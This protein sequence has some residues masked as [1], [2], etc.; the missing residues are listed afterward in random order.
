MLRRLILGE[1]V[2][3][4]L[5]AGATADFLVRA[6]GTQ[7]PAKQAPEARFAYGGNAA[8]IPAQF[9]GKL[10]FLPVRVSDAQ[11]SLFELDSTAAN[12][13]IAP[14]RASELKLK[15]LTGLLLTLPDVQ[16]FLPELRTAAIENFGTQVGHEYQGTL[17]SDFLSLVVV[18]IDY[19]RQT[20]RIYDPASFKHTG[21]IAPLPLNFSGGLP[22]VHA[23]F[24]VGGERAHEADFILNTA[25]D[26][27]VILSDRFA[28]SHKLFSAHIKSVPASDPEIDHGES[29]VL[30]RLKGFQLGR[31]VVS[32]PIAAFS[33]KNNM[34]GDPNLAGS[35]GG[36]LLCRFTVTL[37]FAHHQLYLDPNSQFG[38]EQEEDKSGMSLVA[39]GSNLRTFVVTQVRPGTPAADVGIQKG[40]ILAGVDDEPAANIT[41]ADARELFRRI[42]YKDKLLLERNGQEIHVTLQTR[43]LL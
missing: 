43:R 36:A 26:A 35:I 14:A 16:F 22:I 21:E 24:T 4:A 25:L 15:N 1:I 10:V 7:S 3:A 34:A 2:C 6:Q 41:L 40:D 28:E 37:D 31:A 12:S 13:S 39:Q 17:G 5:L 33:S 30:G 9:I 29:V 18:E 32:G 11:P 38:N 8:Q 23:K 19:A 42:G 27:A 20:V